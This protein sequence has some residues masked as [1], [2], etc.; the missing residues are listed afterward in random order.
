MDMPQR[1]P[2]A[3]RSPYKEILSKEESHHNWVVTVMRHSPLSRHLEELMC[4]RMGGWEVSLLNSG[5]RVKPLLELCLPDQDDEFTP[6]TWIILEQI[7]KICSV[8]KGVLT[9]LNAADLLKFLLLLLPVLTSKYWTGVHNSTQ[10]GK[11]IPP[12]PRDPVLLDS[13]DV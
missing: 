11:T 13:F 12:V 1:R 10:T 3:A 9:S 4:W 2:S 8:S 7:G 6:N 5:V